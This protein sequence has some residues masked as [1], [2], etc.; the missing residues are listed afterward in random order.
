M[1][2][3]DIDASSPYLMPLLP[4]HRKRWWEKSP[5]SYYFIITWIEIYGLFFR[6]SFHR[7]GQN[8]QHLQWFYRNRGVPA[9]WFVTNQMLTFNPKYCF[10]HFLPLKCQGR[11]QRGLLIWPG[12]L[13]KCCQ[14]LHFFCWIWPRIFSCRLSTPNRSLQI[15]L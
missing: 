5:I 1:S 9:P 11:H 2:H 4:C 7:G 12:S 6:S 15:Y 13:A 3:F 10:Q 14:H 8:I